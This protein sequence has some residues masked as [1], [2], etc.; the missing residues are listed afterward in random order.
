MTL[1][2]EI[3]KAIT[4]LKQGVSPGMPLAP[5]KPVLLLAVF[6]SFRLGEINENKIYITAELISRFRS[7]WNQLVTS[8]HTPNFSLPFFHLS[9]EKSKIWHLNVKPGFEKALTSSRSIKSLGMLRELSN[10]AI[11][12][13]DVF[14]A[15]QD[16]SSNLILIQTLLDTYF[17]GTKLKNTSSNY[18]TSIEKKLLSDSSNQYRLEFEAEFKLKEKTEIEEEVF[19]R[20]SVFRKT[21]PKIYNDTCAIS[22]MRIVANGISMVD[23]CHIIPFSESHDDTIGNGIALSPTIHRA[24]DRGLISIGLEYKVLVSKNFVESYSSSSLHQFENKIVRLP[25]NERHYP[26]QEN[27][28]QHRQRFGFTN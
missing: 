2:R 5:H 12:R 15:I 20:S 21:I 9:R 17:E 25:E 27:L 6:E 24:F 22:G 16:A 3:F 14:V 7:I 19:L 1:D 23:A 26:K 10:Y 11:L 8:N 4:S 28:E 18:L 13:D